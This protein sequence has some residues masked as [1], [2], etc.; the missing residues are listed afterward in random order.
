MTR[1]IEIP[2]EKLRIWPVIFNLSLTL[3]LLHVKY[4][5]FNGLQQTTTIRAVNCTM[6]F[7]HKLSKFDVKSFGE[8]Y[9]KLHPILYAY[10][11]KFINDPEVAKDLVQDA[12]IKLWEDVDVSVIHTS[13]TLYL[14]KT[15]HNLCL[16]HLRSEQIHHRFENHAALKLREAE[17]DFFSHENN[18]YTSIFLK[19]IESIIHKCVEQLPP[20]SRQI[21]KMSRYENKSYSEIAAELNISIRTVENHI[22][23][24]LKILKKELGDYLFFLFIF[25]NALI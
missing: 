25:L 19:D 9:I 2:T 8:L 5:Y 13:I 23:R 14:K 1:K 16:L 12:F 6:E 20:Q 18:C 17:L 7:K 10:S 22:F 15:V 11:R 21:F 24:S 4:E 3:R